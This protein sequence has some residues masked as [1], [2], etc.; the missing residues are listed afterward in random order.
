MRFN[1]NFALGFGAIIVANLGGIAWSLLGPNQPVEVPAEDLMNIVW[2]SVAII[3]AIVCLL[4]C[5][6]LPRPRSEERFE[7]HWPTRIRLERQLGPLREGATLCD[8]SA[9]GARVALP[10]GMPPPAVGSLIWCEFPELDPLRGRVVRIGQGGMLGLVWEMEAPERRRLIAA[11][12][13]QAP[14]NIAGTGDFRRALLGLWGR[15]RNP[16]A[17][18]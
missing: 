17:R 16:D 13:S 15:V 9:G 8:I 1:R 10:E 4:V 6:E 2:A 11:L 12:F 14:E 18:R 3:L 7:L 5:C